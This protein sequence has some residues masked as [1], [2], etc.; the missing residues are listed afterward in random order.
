MLK[1]LL[2][3]YQML[4]FRRTP[5]EVPVSATLLGVTIGLFVITSLLV[6]A[7]L[8]SAIDNIVRAGLDVA[9]LL[10]FVHF[11]L[12]FRGYPERFSQT[13]TALCTVF[14]VI[15]LLAWPAMTQIARLINLPDKSAA[16]VSAIFILILF[17]YSIAIMGHILKHALSV[18]FLLGLLSSFGYACLNIFLLGLVFPDTA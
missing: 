11:L 8:F 17:I 14:I 1:Y 5:Q 18:T 6:N 4:L 9:L 10:L 16:E 3:I 13:I 2:F 7:A 15:N 12:Q